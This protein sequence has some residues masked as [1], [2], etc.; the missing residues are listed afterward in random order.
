MNGEIQ[1]ARSLYQRG[2]EMLLDLGNAVWVAANGIHLGNIELNGDDLTRAE[3]QMRED[4]ELLRRMGERYRLPTV[5][6][7]LAKV[8]RDQGRDDEALPFLASAEEL[9]SPSDVGTQ[10]FWRAVRAPILAR[11]GRFE[12]A[13]EL[14]R[15]AVAM[16]RETESIGFEA[17]ALV[18]LA[19]VLSLSAKRDEALE[20]ADQAVALYQKKGNVVALERATALRNAL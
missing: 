17:D 13:E 14:A 8:I 20:V 7:L 15:A 10:A 19:T 9:T 18:E 2:R 11:Q 3:K 4:V 6:A 5:S 12:E 16:L 1:V